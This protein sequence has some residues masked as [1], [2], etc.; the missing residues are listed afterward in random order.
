M[1]PPACA[2]CGH[3]A[4]P[5]DRFCGRCGSALPI[6]CARCQRVNAHGLTYCTGCGDPLDGSASDTHEERRRVSVLFIDAVGSTAL[7]EGTDPE[8]VRR[9]QTAFYATVRKVVRRYGGVVEK[10]IGDAAMVLFG[11]P[12]ATETDPVRCVR[13]GLDLQQALARPGEL[14]A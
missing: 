5:Q 4:A 7:A 11:A 6:P 3:S 14:T 13:A 8:A 2:S 1:A 10:Y 9:L 12:I